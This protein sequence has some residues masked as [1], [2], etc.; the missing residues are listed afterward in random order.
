M[1][2][3]TFRGISTMGQAHNEQNKDTDG[4][5]IHWSPTSVPNDWKRGMNDGE[6]D[7]EVESED[8]AGGGQKGK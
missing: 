3:L 8:R 5:G 1:C 7:S 2:L 4:P 6:I